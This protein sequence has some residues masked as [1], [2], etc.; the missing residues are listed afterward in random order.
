VI[1]DQRRAGML[2]EIEQAFSALLDA[3]QGIT[4][5]RDFGG[6]FYGQRSRGIGCG[7]GESSPEE[8]SGAIQNGSAL[9]GGAV[10]RIGRR[11]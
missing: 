11:F 2:P 3:R 5:P 7:I 9:I 10:V 4:Q 8:N 6:G 1:V